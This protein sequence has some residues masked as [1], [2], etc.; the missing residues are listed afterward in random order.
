M[1][2][3]H[4]QWPKTL[5]RVSLDR[6]CW[7]LRKQRG[8]NG[9]G[10]LGDSARKRWEDPGMIAWAW[11]LGWG[12]EGWLSDPR[13]GYFVSDLGLHPGVDWRKGC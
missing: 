5:S 12:W 6:V 2:H 3:P 1:E 8:S 9:E 11:G 4:A 13:M 7:E 10:I